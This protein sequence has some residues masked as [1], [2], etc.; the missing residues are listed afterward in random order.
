MQKVNTKDLSTVDLKIFLDE[1]QKRLAF[2][3]SFN[4]KNP[5]DA[6]EKLYLQAAKR[7]AALDSEMHNRLEA[8]VWDE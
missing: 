6:A 8:L 1:A 7:H 4:M 3:V 5:N 2:W